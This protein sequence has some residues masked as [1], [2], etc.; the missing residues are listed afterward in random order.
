MILSFF[1]F[2]GHIAAAFA[3]PTPTTGWALGG[4]T[5]AG[6]NIIGAVVILPVTR[7]LTST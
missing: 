6:Y 5:Y 2:G 3:V 7:H 1:K 4:L